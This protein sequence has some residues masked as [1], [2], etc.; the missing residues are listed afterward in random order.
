M[1]DGAGRGAGGGYLFCHLLEVGLEKISSVTA[2]GRKS[3][4]D[5]NK[6]LPDP[7]LIINDSFL[8]NS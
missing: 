4:G 2:G 7:H 3:F 5:S 8:E 1:K 6:N